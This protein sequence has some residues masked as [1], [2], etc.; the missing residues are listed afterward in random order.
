MANVLAQAGNKVDLA[1]FLSDELI[2]QAL[3]G[4]ILVV[5]G[6]C[7]NEDDVLYSCPSLTTKKLI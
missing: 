7:T 6:G 1:R 5:S 4:A 2:A 3:A